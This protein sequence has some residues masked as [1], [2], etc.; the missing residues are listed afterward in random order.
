M[1]DEEA[2]TEQKADMR[3]RYVELVLNCC[4]EERNNGKL[5]LQT[6]FDFQ[7]FIST[8]PA[9][10]RLPTCFIS[11]LNKVEECQASK[12]AQ[13]FVAL[14]TY[15]LNLWDFPWKKDFWHISV[16]PKI[17]TLQLFLFLNGAISKWS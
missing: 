12:V 11:I 14:E 7:E 5:E 6:Q 4:P 10:E 3:S 16:S 9:T 17:C 15:T 2:E 13:V 1:S 8:V